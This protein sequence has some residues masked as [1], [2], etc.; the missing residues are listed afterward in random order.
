MALKNYSSKT[1]RC[2]RGGVCLAVMLAMASCAGVQPSP[3]KT[4]TV[5]TKPASAPV[6]AARPIPAP[7]AVEQPSARGTTPD[8]RARAAESLTLEGSRLVKEKNFDGAI[9]VLEQAVGVNP[10]DGPACYYLAEAWIGKQD[11][12]RATQFNDLAALYLRGD[13]AWSQRVRSQR[14][15]IDGM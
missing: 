14:A 15:R 13:K 4:E 11:P 10:Q 6:P 2:F 5:R 1:S 7:P 12:A 3:E 9:R 8:A